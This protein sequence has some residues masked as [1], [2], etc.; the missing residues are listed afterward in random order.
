MRQRGT[1]QVTPT[2]ATWIPA[3]AGMTFGEIDRPEIPHLCARNAIVG[4]DDTWVRPYTCRDSSGA[5]SIDS[6]VRRVSDYVCAEPWAGTASLCPYT[7]HRS[8]GGP[9]VFVAVSPR[10]SFTFG[11]S[12]RSCLAGPRKDQ[13]RAFES[14]RAN[15]F[16]RAAVPSGASGMCGGS[17]FGG[18]TPLAKRAWIHPA[19]RPSI[20]LNR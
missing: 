20:R 8:C 5:Q 7:G 6:F 16:P 11:Q 2:R 9:V 14:K 1:L 3:F 19:L 17:G 18:G 10:M 12:L 15:P 13:R 4:S